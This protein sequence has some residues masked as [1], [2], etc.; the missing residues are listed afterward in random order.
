MSTFEDMVARLAPAEAI[1]AP[2]HPR[3]LT[4]PH[5]E[6]DDAPFDFA[7]AVWE[8]PGGAPAL[9]AALQPLVEAALLVELSDPEEGR[10]PEA[11]HLGC[12][13]PIDD[14]ER[15]VRAFGFQPATAPDEFVRCVR[16]EASSIGR[17][18]PDALAHCFRA[19]VA[20]PHGAA[21][22][23]QLR[24][25]EWP[26]FG[27]PPGALAKALGLTLDVPPTPQG[28]DQVEAALV[29]RVV[30]PIRWIGS[31]SF[32]GL[33]DFVALVLH[34]AFEREVQW[35]PSEP[36]PQTGLRPPPLVRMR[37]SEG[38]VHLPIGQHVLQW[39]VMPLL[40]GEDV[41]LLS[42]WCEDQARA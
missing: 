13:A 22:E 12:A 2:V 28:L 36:D 18:P 15:A 25:L 17:E 3:V 34:R 30:G 9:H 29:S 42:H 8:D 38:W 19:E 6:G 14:V 11:L 16:G 33:C 26:P 35:A 37:S 4:L 1:E 5:G 23:S 32:L 31:R 39:C 41:P 40:P 24:A 7:F 27:E 21:I 10:A 20:A